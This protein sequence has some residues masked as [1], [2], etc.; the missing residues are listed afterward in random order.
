LPA[1]ALN[2]FHIEGWKRFRS[3]SATCGQFREAVERFLRT[4]RADDEQ[5]VV[6]AKRPI[7]S[8]NVDAGFLTAASKASALRGLL[9]F[10][11]SFS[12]KRIRVTYLA[13]VH[14]FSG[15]FLV[16]GFSLKSNLRCRGERSRRQ[17]VE[18]TSSAE[19]F[20]RFIDGPEQ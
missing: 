9:D 17:M 4:L 2:C 13:I 11:S 8:L 20:G 14:S 15:G 18:P 19:A 12:V 5:S 16:E 3:D 6:S 10:A 7:L 1:I